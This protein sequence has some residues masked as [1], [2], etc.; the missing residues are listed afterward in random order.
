MHWM[1]FSV[2]V[3]QICHEEK[4]ECHRTVGNSSLFAL[5]EV[6]DDELC[7]IWRL[8]QEKD[9]SL[10]VLPS[11]SVVIP[12]REIVQ[13]QSQSSSRP[14]R[15]EES[16][17]KPRQRGSHVYHSCETLSRQFR[18]ISRSS[19]H[20]SLNSIQTERFSRSVTRVRK[21]SGKA[22]RFPLCFWGFIS[23]SVVRST[24]SVSP[25]VQPSA[26]RQSWER[27]I[28]NWMTHFVE[29]QQ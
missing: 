2:T 28:N 19:S 27:E 26:R 13:D 8:A 6:S 1:I 10:L 7:S 12:T 29:N 17:W 5:S 24:R 21:C 15:R 23:S 4:E 22:N 9:G 11:T 3:K 16:S 25:P 14:I 20:L 18:E